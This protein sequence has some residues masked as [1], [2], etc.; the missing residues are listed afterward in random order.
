MSPDEFV[1]R[2]DKVR[3]TGRGRWIAC[4]PA[5]DDRIPSL[6]VGEGSDGRVLVHC[7]GGCSV[8]QVVGAVGLSLSEIMPDGPAPV[9]PAKRQRIPPKDVLEAMAF[10]ALVVAIAASDIAQGKTLSEEERLKLFEIA[11]EFH[12]AIEY[13]TGSGRA[14]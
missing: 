4:C 14:S 10:N 1:S 5:H 12:E 11:G 7:F 6:T 8:E 3:S 2:L 13:V 9:M